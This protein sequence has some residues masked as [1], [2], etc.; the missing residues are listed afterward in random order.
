MN[1]YIGQKVV[2]IDKECEFFAYNQIYEIQGI[3]A[4]R[5]NYAGLDLFFGDYYDGVSYCGDCNYETNETEVW[6]SEHSF[7][8]LADISELEQILNKKEHELS[9]NTK[10]S[11]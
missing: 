8:P 11:H 9:I 1:W 3:S 6:Q 10:G 2:C 5:C 4:S 7:A